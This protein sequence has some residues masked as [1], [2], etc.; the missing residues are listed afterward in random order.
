MLQ[1]I[2]IW[3]NVS[4]IHMIPFREMIWFLQGQRKF[5]MKVLAALVLYNLLLAW[6]GIVTRLEQNTAHSDNVKYFF[7]PFCF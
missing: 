4:L 1:A 5:V 7:L 2:L 3:E 6:K